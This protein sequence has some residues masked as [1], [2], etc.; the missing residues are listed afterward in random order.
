VKKILALVL[1]L[2]ALAGCVGTS[3]APPELEEEPKTE[4]LIRASLC[5]T[6]A[7]S[8][9]CYFVLSD[10]GMLT[11]EIGTRVG[12]DMTQ[13]PFIMAD[14]V[15]S[16]E[17]ETKQLSSSEV[18]AIFALANKVYEGDFGTSAYYGVVDDGWD[19]QMLYKDQVIQQDSWYGFPPEVQALVDELMR[20]SPMEIVWGWGTFRSS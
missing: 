4:E 13:S 2:S 1:I 5:P 10:D 7:W 17:A 12:D 14:N 16:Y 18:D 3:Q 19:V 11:V 8:G 6:S 20:I 9:T 15:Y